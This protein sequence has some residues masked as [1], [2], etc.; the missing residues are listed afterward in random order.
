M[1]ERFW[2]LPR[3]R[4]ERVFGHLNINR[5]IAHAIRP[6]RRI[7]FPGMLFLA[8]ARYWIKFVYAP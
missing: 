2:T 4:I 7:S 1:C 5:A 6:G 8:S 3:N